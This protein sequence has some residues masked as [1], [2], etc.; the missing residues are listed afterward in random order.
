MS[1]SM[2]PTRTYHVEKSVTYFGNELVT[3]FTE[4]T[5][6]HHD[7]S[8]SRMFCRPTNR[9]HNKSTNKIELVLGLVADSRSKVWPCPY[10]NRMYGYRI[11]AWFTSY[12]TI[13]SNRFARHPNVD[14]EPFLLRM[15]ATHVNKA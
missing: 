6:Y 9:T 11:L 3:C 5:H 8:S 4:A 10:T 15:L 13:E 1:H 12:S 7:N 2:P 14:G